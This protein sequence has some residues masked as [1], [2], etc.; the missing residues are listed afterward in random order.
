MAQP[1]WNTPTGSIGSF[2]SG[3][4]LK[5]VVFQLSASA[6]L[7][8]VSISY[9][10]IS[11]GL[12]SGVTMNVNG[13]ISGVPAAV[14]AATTYTFVVRATDNYQ[15]IRDNTFSMTISGIAHPTF[16]TTPGPIPNPNPWSNTQPNSFLDS[17]WVEIPI[18]Y[19]NPIST[20]PVIIRV[21]AGE[22]PPGLEI[23]EYGLIRG[24]A[25]PP[26][27][28]VNLS[29]VS[30][31]ATAVSS[32]IITCLNTANF[33]AGR[34]IV[35]SGTSFG[36]IVPNQTYYIASVINGTQFTVSNT[37]NGPIVTFIDSS[38]YMPI[39]LPSITQGQPTS[40][41]FN[42]VL[43]LDSALGSDIQSYSISVVNQNTPVQ[44]GGPGYGP[45]TRIPA[46]YNTR[47]E[48]F[49]LDRNITEFGYYVLPANGNGT[50]Y[51][52]NQP[53]F[54]GTISSNNKFNFSI[55]GHDF[56][57]NDLQ[58]NFSSLPL[59]LTGNAT[60]G[61]ITGNPVIS[62]N[63][64]SE[65]TFSVSVTKVVLGTVTNISS[66]TFTFVFRVITNIN[67][68]IVWISPADLGTVFNGLPSMAY[69]KATSDI[70]LQYRLT[71]GTLP[72]NL[73]LLPNGELSGIVAFQPENTF[74]NPDAS[75]TFTFTVQAF[76]TQFASISSSQTFTLTVYQQFPNPTDILYIKCTP[77]IA[78]R[79]L[80]ATLLD[81]DTL[82]PPD[83]LY[84]SDDIFFGKAT[85]VIY[86]HAYGINASGIDQYL[87]A[88]TKNH[89][90]RQ[91]TLGEIKTAIARNDYTGEILYEVVYS[92][93]YDNL[94]NYNEI[95]GKYE[96]ESQSNII[97]P[98]GESVAKQIYWQRPIPLYLGPWY[99]SEDTIFTS[100]NNTPNGELLYTSRTPGY[101]RTV[102]PN[103]LPNMRQQVVD[104]L[105]QNQNY[106]ILPLWMTSQ[107]RN[108][109]TL[110]FTPAWV[111]AY[112]KPGLTTLPDGTEVSYAQYIQY[113]IQNNW[114]N[115]IGEK[116]A[117]NLINFKIDRFSVNKSATY[118][119]DNT[120]SPPAWTALPSADPTPTPVDAKDFYVLF[121]QQTI[122]PGTT[123]Y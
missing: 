24:Y 48:T 28:N 61:W 114:L 67:G 106:E 104:V 116:Q 102:Y 23:N 7:P 96:Y 46:I 86:E 2:P 95:E 49:Q 31:V 115:P 19:N 119:F 103:S 87:A 57:G 117:L 29:P 21:V 74:Q 1:I 109:S 81:N 89:Y 123:Q 30:T 76:S 70:D 99:D 35:F 26:L 4:S 59:G 65:F 85:S 112:C 15:N 53:A 44:Q 108:G 69:V 66:P 47:P 58:Y 52:P 82:I 10:I 50:T 22:L 93:V 75:A 3:N 88:I 84:R 54:I 122:L 78:D 16:T 101:V 80:L 121:E 72:P 97:I 27:V 118:N 51:P 111:I 55:L 98:Q 56:D 63:T 5:P 60:T 79:N 11:G 39:L 62:P 25:Q 113:Q 107:Q 100:W 43:K 40:K 12:P 83:Y 64:V 18:E 33:I 32:N 71:S 13:L 14:V 36:G 42:F 73:T 77:S 8:A 34:P 68:D 105:G 20:N 41:T 92:E 94:V 17:T 90:W 45:N 37:V 91:L 9:Q 6:V 120:L 110:G 38:G